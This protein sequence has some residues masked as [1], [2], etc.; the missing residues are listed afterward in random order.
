V[1]KPAKPLCFAPHDTDSMLSNIALG[2]TFFFFSPALSPTAETNARPT[3]AKD[4]MFILPPLRLAQLD[5]SIQIRRVI[6]LV[7]P[8]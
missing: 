3:I 1:P 8:Q 5:S 2:A 6:P 7:N 4:L